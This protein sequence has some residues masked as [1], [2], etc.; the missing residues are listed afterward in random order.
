[1]PSGYAVAT[2]EATVGYWKEFPG[3]NTYH[4]STI[5]NSGLQDCYPKA[6]SPVASQVCSSRSGGVRTTHDFSTVT[7]RYGSSCFSNLNYK[8]TV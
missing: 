2:R 6:V 1:M 4:A 3:S 5:R 8:Q 7:V